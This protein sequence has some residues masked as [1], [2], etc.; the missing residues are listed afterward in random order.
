MSPKKR[1]FRLIA[2]LSNDA[3]ILFM[4]NELSR[5]FTPHDVTR[6]TSLKGNCL[7]YHL[8]KLLKDKLVIRVSKGCYKVTDL[9][10]R[11][12]RMLEEIGPK[13]SKL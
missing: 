12:V 6:E 7:Y 9:G 13:E 4:M 5:K 1:R 3:L 2:S 11:V 8:K 10:Q